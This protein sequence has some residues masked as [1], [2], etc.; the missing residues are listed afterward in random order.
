[1]LLTFALQYFHCVAISI[2]LGKR[3]GFPCDN[4]TSSHIA[5]FQIISLSPAL[6]GVRYRTFPVSA[7]SWKRQCV[8]LH[9]TC[10]R[11]LLVKHRTD[12]PL[13]LRRFS[14][15]VPSSLPSSP[16][17]TRSQSAPSVPFSKLHHNQGLLPRPRSCPLDSMKY[18]T[19]V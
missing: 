5:K 11:S 13:L 7:Q 18:P 19:Y 3:A 4:V 10:L 9:H 1:M 6:C 2:L 14:I 8:P 12:R 15:A 16:L 17:P